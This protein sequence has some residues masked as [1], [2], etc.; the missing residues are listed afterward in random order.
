[1]RGVFLL[2][3]GLML[4]QT[5]ACRRTGVPGGSPPASRDARTTADAGPPSPAPGAAEPPDSA[6]AAASTAQGAGATS[7][8]DEPPP[9]RGTH[10]ALLYSANL[11]G[12]YEAHPLGG[13]ARRATLTER[14]RADADAVINIDAGNLLLPRSPPLEEGMLP[15]EPAEVERRARLLLAGLARMRLDAFTP[16]ETDLRLGPRRLR[17]L[18]RQMKVPL[19]ASN[20]VDA[21]GRPWFGVDRMVTAAGLKVGIF[22]LVRPS[23]DETE[24]WQAEGVVAIPPVEAAQ[25]AVAALR[26]RGAVLVVGLFQLAGGHAEAR[27][28]VEGAPGI[29]FVVLGHED[30]S[31][32]TDQLEQAGSTRLLRPPRLGRHLGRLDLHVVEGSLRFTDRHAP[33]RITPLS[34][35]WLE[36]K[37]HRLDKTIA[38]HPALATLVGRYIAETRRRA[39]RGLPVGLGPRPAW[40]APLG[41]KAGKGG[42]GGRAANPPDEPREIWTYGSNGACVFCHKPAMEQWKTTAHAF[43]LETLRKRGRDK[44]PDC[45]RCHTT[46]FMQPGGTRSVRT[47]ITYFADV[48]CE[49]CHGPSVDHIRAQNKTGTVLEAPPEVCVVCH[50][51]EQTDGEFDYADAMKRVLG[52]GHG[53]P[54]IQ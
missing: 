24:R 14:T 39:D 21:A 9:P 16:G 26:A 29:D 54:E 17:E 41:G 18:C 34:G 8:A 30:G 25:T 48:G 7:A 20:L 47:A 3:V 33:G 52:P 36:H 37:Q 4:A 2:V 27:R 38:D 53:A 23:S 10:I 15:P 45:L 5:A 6:G 42:K 22:G 35:S 49:S 19:V 1:M 40:M 28:I 12:E 43:A 13:L 51:P 32:R 11:L 31:G 50:T 44:D 46:G